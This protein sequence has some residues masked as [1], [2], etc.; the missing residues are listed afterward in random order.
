MEKSTHFDEED[1]SESLLSNR[2]RSPSIAS[3]DSYINRAL[4]EFA[5]E[6]DGIAEPLATQLT[7]LYE[8]YPARDQK[9]IRQLLRE[10]GGDVEVCQSYRCRLL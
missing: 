5:F 1:N 3:T 7:F 9:I 6:Q 4:D 2:S 8:L 10:Q